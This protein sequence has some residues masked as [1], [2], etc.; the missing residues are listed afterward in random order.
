LCVWKMYLVSIYIVF[1]TFLPGLNYLISAVLR[2]DSKEIAFVVPEVLLELQQVL[3]FINFLVFFKVVRRFQEIFDFEWNRHD[4]IEEWRE[5]RDKT[6]KFCNRISFI[7]HVN[8]HI[9]GL[10]YFSIPTLVFMLKYYSGLDKNI[11][12]STP[13]L[14]E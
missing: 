11:E 2:R 10:V 4:D 5:L 6:A 12:K 9:T 3:S 7:N 8:M 13:I 14:V 1:F